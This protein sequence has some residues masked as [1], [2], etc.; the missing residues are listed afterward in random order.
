MSWPQPKKKGRQSEREGKATKY[1]RGK[2]DGRGEGVL[3]K[4]VK[5]FTPQWA[6]ERLISKNA[7]KDLLTT[8]YKVGSS[9]STQ[10]QRQP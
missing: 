5:D 9:K 7:K 1:Q 2:K 4:A 3:S 10:G 6:T 8:G